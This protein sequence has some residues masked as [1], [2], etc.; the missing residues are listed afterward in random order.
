MREE[1]NKEKGC[2]TAESEC[3]VVWYKA[4]FSRIVNS[5]AV[6]GAKAKV[7]EECGNMRIWC[8]SNWANGGY[9]KFRVGAAV[10]LCLLAFKGLFFEWGSSS[11][12]MQ[13]DNAQKER[14]DAAAA[15][16]LGA[17]LGSGESESSSSSSRSSNQPQIHMWTCKK[18]GRQIQSRWPPST[19][20]QCKVWS[21]RN[22]G[23]KNCQFIQSY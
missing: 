14:D 8:A 12:I 21:G 2:S 3:A 19:Q 6:Q 18:C 20:I 22:D 7:C 11:K 4:L 1:G 16:F 17:V 5:A 15:A 23:T 13:Q 9:G 10:V